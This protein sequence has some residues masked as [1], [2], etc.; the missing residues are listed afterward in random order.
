M[1][2]SNIWAFVSLKIDYPQFQ[3]SWKHRL[4][5]LDIIWL[6]TVWERLWGCL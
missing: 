3:A 2:F 5:T 4:F 1:F 6:L